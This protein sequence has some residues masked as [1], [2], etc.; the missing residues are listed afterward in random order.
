MWGYPRNRGGAVQILLKPNGLVFMK[1]GDISVH[2]EIRLPY[3]VKVM[4]L[5]LWLFSLSIVHCSNHLSN[6]INIR[7]STH[8]ATEDTDPFH[9][10]CCQT[11]GK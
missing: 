7:S 2:F 11:Q 9:Y 10:L 3:F 4:I 8:L 6:K 5:V 1:V